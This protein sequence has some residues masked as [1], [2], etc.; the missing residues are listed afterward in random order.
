MKI[1]QFFIKGNVVIHTDIH[2][3]SYDSEKSQLLAQGFALHGDQVEAL[4]V[5]EAYK[6]IQPTTDVENTEYPLLGRLVDMPQALALRAIL[7]G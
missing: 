2:A 1:F 4:S 6:Q 7:G 5:E 3:E